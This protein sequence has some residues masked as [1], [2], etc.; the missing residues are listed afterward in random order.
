M[1]NMGNWNDEFEFLKS[2]CGDMIN[3]GSSTVE[4]ERPLKI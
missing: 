1:E 2:I 3:V 4:V